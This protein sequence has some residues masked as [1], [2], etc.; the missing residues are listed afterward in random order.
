MEN[1]A[2]IYP[3]GPVQPD[4]E[5]IKPSPAFTQ[6]V[7]R[8]IGA[9]LLF[10]VT[11]VLLFV[12]VIAL[13]TGACLLGYAILSIGQ[14]FMILLCGGAIIIA[15]LMLIYFVIK[16]MFKRT[17]VSFDGMLEVSRTEQPEL[18]NF[19][20]RLTEETGASKPKKIFISSQVN[21]SVF[22]N[23]P[24][25]SM[26]FPVPKNLNIGLG[27]VTA[28]NVSE[29]KAVMAH[30]FGHF[31]QRSMKFGSYV[32]NFNKVIHNMLYDNEGYI[33]ALNRL[34]RIHGVFSI[35]AYLNYGIVK[36]IQR[37]LRA[38]Y[39]ILNKT[40]LRLSR[41]M[42]F[43]ADAMAAYASG[44][45]NAVSSFKRISVA[46][47]CYNN[48]LDYWNYKFADSK[49]ALN[50]C[51]QHQEVIKLY[52]KD[53]EIALDAYGL[54]VIYGNAEALKSSDIAIEEQWSS[55]P[56]D[57]DR[58]TRLIQTG[59]TADVIDIPAWTLFRD[60]EAL[61]QRI[62]DM[63]YENTEQKP[64]IVAVDVVD[65]VK[66]FTKDIA[67][68]SYNAAYKGYYN[69]RNIT[70][71]DLNAVIAEG[72]AHGRT[73]EDIFSRE[74]TFVPK[75][76]SRLENDRAV[77]DNIKVNKDIKTFD[78]KGIRY[79]KNQIDDVQTLMDKEIAERQ[80]QIQDIDKEA[81]LYFYHSASSIHQ[82]KLKERY[83]QLYFYQQAATTDYKMYGEAMAAMQPVYTK[84]QPEQIRQ[85][86][87]RVNQLEV[88]LRR[89]LKELV[90]DADIKPYI[91]ETQAEQ[92]NKYADRAVS[93]YDDS[94]NN[95]AIENFNKALNAYITVINQRIYETKK[96][97][98]NFQLQIAG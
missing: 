17:P 10:I 58:E 91:T 6:Q 92:I 73:F 85:T 57:E 79:Q 20:D 26:F 8:A 69:S 94:Y 44:S 67:D 75:I 35:F 47:L 93:Y 41:E 39:I 54:P 21:A 36:G 30:E 68:N 9:V 45:N 78:Y 88:P 61:Q 65:F 66:E 72:R 43:H 74:N 37:I 59:I 63:L 40:H 50:F 4:P 89:R 13:A 71:F 22:Y 95:Y 84:M 98:L 38:V 80:R 2:L 81:F 24:F 34:G 77:L 96:D 5:I 11:Y 53:N 86:V 28:L 7:Y 52:A 3:P 51:T 55:H 15:G 18:F 16:F 14:S 31:S 23:S 27:L 12:S 60:R 48:L 29:F 82:D 62:T 42:E 33:N 1:T 46:A 76:I 83:R 90:A 32:Y 49:R 56:S 25:W 19:I 97:L 87:A 70:E 64:D